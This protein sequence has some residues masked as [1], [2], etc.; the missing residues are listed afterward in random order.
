LQ[1]RRD[2]FAQLRGDL[3]VD[4]AIVGGGM[5]GAIAAYLFSE[6]GVRVAVAEAHA[7]A[8]GSTAAST[9]LLMQEPDRDLPELERRYGAARARKIWMS[10][11]RAT[12]DLSA[13]IK[14]LGIDCDY[15]PRQSIYYTLDPDRVFRLEQELRARKRA[16]LPGRWLSPAALHRLTGIAGQGAI[17]TSGNAEVNPVKACRG[18][19]RAAVDN[20]AR[21][22]ERSSV[23]R[24][25]R[26]PDGVSVQTAGGVI[27]ANQVVVATG[28]AT[29]EF[30]PLV[31]RFRMKDTFVIAT[32]RLPRHLRS[33][34]LEKSAMLWDTDR[35]Y[36]YLRWTDDG[37]L[38]LGGEDVDHRSRRGAAARLTT[39]RKRLMA[40]LARIYP[41]LAG[42]RPEYAWEGLFAE[43]SDGLP[44]VGTHRRYPGHL[45]ALGYGGNGMTASFLAAQ[46]LLRRYRKDPDPRELLF[47][48]SR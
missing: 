13:A 21:V 20:G 14:S 23:K 17:L 1:S 26:T 18:F 28:Y 34:V 30:R 5:T 12:S 44:Y 48:F 41:A 24:I 47:A 38:L 36:H 31:G 29:R 35:P 46:L 9:A 25:A 8:A 43:T 40:Y 7:V 15:H 2:R 4:V 22:Y 6:A 42:E 16:G 27:Q 45:F 3:N 11:R 39:G 33:A 37:R 32:R 19:I 10:L